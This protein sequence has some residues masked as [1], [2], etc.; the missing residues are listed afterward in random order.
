MTIMAIMTITNVLTTGA[1]Y[2]VEELLEAANGGYY[3]AK[4]I[5]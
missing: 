5:I 2:V 3:R 4:V 1:K